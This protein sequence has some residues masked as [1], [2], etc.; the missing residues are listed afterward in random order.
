MQLIST[1]NHSTKN[2]SSAAS[3]DILSGRVFLSLFLYQDNYPERIT[4]KESDAFG[5][6]TQW[7]LYFPPLS[8]AQVHHQSGLYQRCA[9]L[10]LADLQELLEGW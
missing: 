4:R 2:H 8:Q 10:P 9:P 7:Y 3:A 6:R 1:N 5:Q